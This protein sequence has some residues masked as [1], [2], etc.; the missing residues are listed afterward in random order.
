MVPFNPPL[1]P[2]YLSVA[3]ATSTSGKPKQPKLLRYVEHWTFKLNTFS[4]LNSVVLHWGRCNKRLMST[5]SASYLTRS[6]H[7]EI[8]IFPAA[9]RSRLNSR[10]TAWGR[11]TQPRTTQCVYAFPF[12]FII[13]NWT[14]CLPIF[15][16]KKPFS[17]E[18]Q[19]AEKGQVLLSRMRG[20]SLIINTK[21]C[22]VRPPIPLK[23][24]FL[25][26]SNP[27]LPFPRFHGEISVKITSGLP[28]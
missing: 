18:G 3:I 17:A 2:S 12:N 26:V 5:H 8:G 9:H 16:Y 6:P 13:I 20:R 21:G 14:H 22:W 1:Q 19:V 28:Y 27:L 10:V 23:G 15:M 25:S 24:M 4:I 7:T 11:K